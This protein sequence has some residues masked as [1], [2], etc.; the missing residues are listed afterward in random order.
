MITSKGEVPLDPSADPK[1]KALTKERDLQQRQARKFYDEWQCQLYGGPTCPRKGDGPLAKTSKADFDKARARV[2]RL[3]RQIEDRRKELAAADESAKANR[4]KFAEEEWPKVR[5]QLDAAIQRQ[6]D[7]QAAFDAENRA[8]NG[9]LIRLQALNEVSSSDPTLRVTHLLL[10]L[11][12]LLIECLPV[13]VKLMQR[14]GNYEKVLAL[15]AKS[16][17]REARAAY[18]PTLG[19]VPPSAGAVNGGGE[20][21]RT[22]IWDIWDNPQS[23]QTAP[24]SPPAG[25]PLPDSPPHGTP[26]P[27]RTLPLSQGTLPTPADPPAPSGDGASWDHDM[28]RAM[29]D[30]RVHRTNTSGSERGG[31]FELFPEDD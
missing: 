21:G 28:L 8:T 16:E 29:Q 17:Y 18:G 9:L 23:A 11:L 22:K 6:N 31:S 27:D 20:Q 19:S 4:L 2:D 7:L 14:P 1:I 30:T 26:L 15:A 12:F 24:P 10:F 5:A 3:N 25:T 13:T